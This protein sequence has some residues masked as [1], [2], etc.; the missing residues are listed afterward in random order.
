M[1]VLKWTVEARS[2]ELK[3]DLPKQHT[4]KVVGLDVDDEHTLGLW[5]ITW[6]SVKDLLW[7]V[8]SCF[9]FS[10]FLL[11]LNCHLA[12]S[13]CISF[14]LPTKNIINFLAENWIFLRSFFLLWPLELVACKSF[15]ASLKIQSFVGC[16][17]CGLPCH[18]LSSDC[19]LF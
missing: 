5:I 7:L 16:L 10:N 4:T 2:N 19:G 14:I 13:C 6:W 3:S 11:L 9:S 15:V 8:L 17:E 12:Y 18:H 1:K